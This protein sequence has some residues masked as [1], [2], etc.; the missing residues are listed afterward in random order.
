MTDKNNDAFL[1]VLASC[2]DAAAGMDIKDNNWMPPDGPYDVQL[3]DLAMGEKEGAA[4]I[5]P[6]F[7][8]VGSEFDGRTFS[9]FFYI[10][11]GVD[12]PTP[13]MRNL[14]RFATCLAGHEV[15]DPIQCAQVIQEAEEAGE[16]LSLEVF[17]STSRKNGKVYTNLRYLVVL[18]STE[19]DE[20]GELIGDPETAEVEV[21]AEVEE[22]APAKATKTKARKAKS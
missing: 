8:I 19:V 15:K 4:W 18:P 7:T 2:T 20:E 3:T 21:E 9:D 11:G 10:P 17:R 22:T 13:G 6:E 14:A 16:F 1:Q 5:R 12:E